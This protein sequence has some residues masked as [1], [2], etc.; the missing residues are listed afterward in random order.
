MRSRVVNWSTLICLW[1]LSFIF[2]L[3][4]FQQIAGFWD[5]GNLLYPVVAR[6]HGLIPN[7]DF[8]NGYPGFHTLLYHFVSLFSGVDLGAFRILTWVIVMISLSFL[9]LLALDIMGLYFAILVFLS[10][11]TWTFSFFYTLNPAFIVF[12]IS[13]FCVFYLYKEFKKSEINLTPTKKSL[14]WVIAIFCGLSLGFK[15]S[16][17][18]NIVAFGCIL[19]WCLKPFTPRWIWFSVRASMTLVPLLMFL[20]SRVVYQFEAI[21]WNGVVVLPW[22]LAVIYV[23][24]STPAQ[25]LQLSLREVF[26]YGALCFV[27]SMAW[28]IYYIANGVSPLFIINEI[29]VRVPKLIDR[30]LSPIKPSLIFI[31]LSVCMALVAVFHKKTGLKRIFKSDAADVVVIGLYCLFAFFLFIWSLR[32][33][34]QFSPWHINSYWSSSFFFSLIIGSF[35]LLK[36]SKDFALKLLFIF[37]SILMASG[38]P[39]INNLIF[40]NGLLAF[41]IVY[42]VWSVVET[43]KLSK[44]SSRFRVFATALVI[45]SFL[46]ANWGRKRFFESL[47]RANFETIGY[48]FLIEPPEFLFALTGEWLAKYLPP[49]SSVGGYPNFALSFALAN[50]VVYSKLPNFIGDREDYSQIVRDLESGKGPDYFLI[51]P[52]MYP[53]AH[54]YL[55]P[56]GEIIASLEKKYVLYGEVIGENNNRVRVYKKR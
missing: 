24:S 2:C 14:W 40:S 38:Y 33:P 35:L 52:T 6:A 16:G 45:A 54:P 28:L 19:S 12:S 17:I 41:A 20:L 26:L 32:N 7:V 53:A 49:N 10:G 25:F 8:V 21:P 56:P 43:R 23:L 47:P 22:I 11:L 13:S 9:Y 30:D 44:I 31:G 55:L 46:M 4:N 50:R 18:F 1:V 29:Y 34:N 51:S 36:N 3:P 48:K 15:Q 39:Y 42:V 27:S 5:D 37:C